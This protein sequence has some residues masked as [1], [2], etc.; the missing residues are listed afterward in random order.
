MSCLV[1]SCLLV[2]SACSR[3]QSATTTDGSLKIH[4]LFTDNMV[5]QRGVA[6][7]IWGWAKPGSKINIKI[8]G[9]NYNSQADYTGRWEVNLRPHQA[10][11][12]YK[13]ELS[14]GANKI[15]LKNILFGDVFLATG[16]SNMQWTVSASAHYDE[17]R[18]KADHYKQIRF[19]TVMNNPLAQ[20]VNNLEGEW[21]V[22]NGSTVG[23]Q[24]G[25]A[26]A[27]AKRIHDNLGVPVGIIHSSVGNTKIEYW[28]S[29]DSL[30]GF[31]QYSEIFS[32]F[33]V[34]FRITLSGT[35]NLADALRHK[36]LRLQISESDINKKIWFNGIH[37]PPDQLDAN[38]YTVSKN[39]L[40]EI[41][42]ITIRLKS[43]PGNLAT[44]ESDITSMIESEVKVLTPL[45]LKI[46]PWEA[47]VQYEQE[48]PTVLFNGMIAPLVP[49]DIKAILWYQGESNLDNV[50]LYPQ[51]F[52]KMVQDWRS[53]F[54]NDKLPFL[55]VQ[56][57]PYKSEDVTNKL[58]AFRLAQS[59]LAKEIPYHYMATSIDLGDADGD[60]HTK[61]KEEIGARLSQLALDHIYNQKN[62]S[63]N[64]EYSNFQHE[65]NA[66]RLFFT[67]TNDGLYLK[68]G[69]SLRCFELVSKSGLVTPAR[70]VIDGSSVLVYLDGA[71]IS[72][73][74]ALRY[75]WSDRPPVN[76]YNFN[77]LPLLPFKIDFN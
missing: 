2:C 27:F 51:L 76:L 49:F 21:V 77:S 68:S 64:L 58:P 20:P 1:L 66:L 44:I 75:A 45:S 42:E 26:Y 6:N 29:R 36:N 33:Q 72:D 12:P 31:N 30:Q 55:S 3:D 19:F 4:G 69:K 74:S 28:M 61:E 52:K 24:S 63:D 70:A 40:K 46:N 16:Q 17:N 47:G 43:V 57:A 59:Q 32:D 23:F 25:V 18:A 41:N 7:E 38:S 5:L 71:T 50:A 8:A 11:G 13:L 53:R 73:Y 39:L 65:G 62:N 48:Y 15:V 14:S 34:P 60:V 35:L 56:L 9:R 10:G 37:I 22:N 54:S 67:N